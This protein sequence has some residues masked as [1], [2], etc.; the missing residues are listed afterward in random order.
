[1]SERESPE[2]S[3][4]SGD[5][6]RASAELA[7]RLPAPIAALARI[8]YNYAW[9]WT[10]GGRAL[11]RDIDRL[12][13]RRSGY[14]PRG[15][16]EAQPPHR[17]QQLASDPEYVRRVE[18]VAAA[19]ESDLARPAAVSAILPGRPVAY[20]CAEFGGHSSL[21][22]YGGG[23][24][25]LAGDFVKAASDLALPVV[26]VSLFYR[27]GY[28]HQ[29][30]DE[31]GGQHE[32]WTTTPIE[33]LPAALVTNG[34]G[35][36]VTISLE[37][38]GRAVRIQIWRIDFGRIPIYLLDADRADNQPIDRWIT[39]RLYVANRQMRLAQYA[40]LG[41]GGVR[42]LRALGIEP[43]LVHLNEGH[44]ALSGLER[45]GVRV[46]AGRP[47]DAA[48]AEVREETVFTTHTP[49]AAG[50]EWFAR[51]DVERA[52]GALRERLQ[53][54][55]SAFYGLGRV[56]P[57]NEQEPVALTPLAL[58][59][60]RTA[61]AV[62]RRHGEVAREMWQPLWPE[63]PTADVPIGHVT[64]GVHVPTWMASPMQALVDRY[65]PADWR[66]RSSDP[67]IWDALA[68]IPDAEL[69]AVRQ[70]LRELLVEDSRERSVV[71]RLARGESHDYV[72]AAARVYDPAV[73]TI[74]FARRV[75][76]YKRLHLLTV[77][78]ERGLRLLSDA[79]RP[80]QLLIA[81]KAHPADQEAKQALRSMLDL[82]RAPNVGGRIVFLEDYDL[83]L[84][85]RVVAGVDLWL[86]LP[87]PP[88]EASGT[89]GM[90]V[91]LNGGLHLS[92]L[93]GWWA[94]A[95]D[96]EN[97]WAIA[98]PPGD[99]HAQDL[100][101]AA[102]L[103]DL[104]E[105]QVVPLFYER[106]RDGVPERWLARVK[107]SMRRLIPRFSAE[108]MVRDYLDTVYVAKGQGGSRRS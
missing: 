36:P 101:D 13:W 19:L 15:L 26:A 18:Q 11:F 105:S 22:L 25:V 28:F 91:V 52:L 5:I 41:C 66:R 90:K 10:P 76:T 82:R 35:H 68:R 45:L 108:R 106:N 27:E 31:E 100:A 43:G 16:I 85:P 79:K 1:V 7:E 95:Y 57:G 33:R 84:A 44:A 60:S 2:G 8:S 29:R 70:R 50:N 78:L 14:N 56:H 17:L 42:A 6:A 12:H 92:V 37:I 67:S 24:G 72:E 77:H 86:N 58:R 83:H 38:N 30:L 80:I 74:G 40:V 94:E 62:S 96:G 32:Y 93:D 20:L 88:F 104:L 49:V 21:P 51:E 69:W 59:T 34:A 61:N 103:Y 3:P 23:L 65:L 102:A 53:V 75:A 107:T 54:P 81:G 98:T 73:L 48:L 46:A 47:L 99:H 87:R 55:S 89:S 4:G 64:N 71:M 63:R 9:S 39:A 97:G